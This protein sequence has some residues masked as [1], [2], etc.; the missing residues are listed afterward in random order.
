M[1]KRGDDHTLKYKQTVRSEDGCHVRKVLAA[2]PRAQIF[3][4][5]IIRDSRSEGVDEAG[6]LDAFILDHD[7]T[8]EPAATFQCI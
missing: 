5:K 4:R 7:T 2:L 3:T 8:K 1:N 6:A